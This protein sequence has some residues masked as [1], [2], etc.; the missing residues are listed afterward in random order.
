MAWVRV[1]LPVPRLWRLC[2]HK[3]QAPQW[4][5]LLGSSGPL[6]GLPAGFESLVLHA[7][8]VQRVNPLSRVVRIGDTGV[9]TLRHECVV[10]CSACRDGEM[11]IISDYESEVLGSTPSLGARCG[12]RR[13]LPFGEATPLMP[14]RSCACSVQRSSTPAFQAGSLGSNPS[15]RSE[16]SVV[17]VQPG[18]ELLLAK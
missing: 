12:V 11:E 6:Q 14:H 13:T 7:E 8:H 17:V 2:L 9:R 16:T 4:G 15:R 5:R 10:A 3:K 1:L 18:L